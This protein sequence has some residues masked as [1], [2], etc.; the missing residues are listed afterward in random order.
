MIRK[1]IAM[2]NQKK[3]KEEDGDEKMEAQNVESEKSKSIER[4]KSSS[5]EK[6]RRRRS[7]SS[8]NIGSHP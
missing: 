4:E 2:I 6:P 5:S 7:S 8:S 3:A 1:E